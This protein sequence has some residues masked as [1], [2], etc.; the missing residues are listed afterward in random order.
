MKPRVVDSA[1]NPE[2]GAVLIIGLEL[3]PHVQRALRILNLLGDLSHRGSRDLER[4]LSERERPG[5]GLVLLAVDVQLEG[6]G[7]VAPIQE[8]ATPF[9]RHV[10]REPV[11]LSDPVEQLHTQ[12]S[13]VRVRVARVGPLEGAVHDL[14][15][16]CQLD[17]IDGS[18]CLFFQGRDLAEKTLERSGRIG[19]ILCRGL[20]WRQAESEERAV[21]RPNQTNMG[22]FE[23]DAAQRQPSDPE[24]DA[25]DPDEDPTGPEQRWAAFSRPG[26]GGHVAGLDAKP[27]LPAQIHR[28][29]LHRAPEQPAQLALDLVVQQTLAQAGGHEIASQCARQHHP[30][31]E[32]AH[33]APVHRRPP[34]FCRGRLAKRP[35]DPVFAEKP[36]G[37][38]PSRD[39]AGH[40][41]TL[42]GRASSAA[43]SPVPRDSSAPAPGMRSVPPK[44]SQLNEIAQESARRR[45]TLHRI[46]RGT[47]GANPG[48]S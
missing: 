10:F 34:H 39:P 12:R 27:V 38:R 5:E 45:R 24:R 20:R 30:Q 36:R 18:G 40:R 43:M 42:R 11:T 7:G 47:P 1:R 48:G 17:A 4:D 44:K 21:H 14:E 2:A 35:S 33:P 23:H 9:D 19:L 41:N 3:E 26:E 37:G 31:P 32:Q 15:P 13:C 8:D 46:K 16:V 22:P 28:A 25:V 6:E 29:D